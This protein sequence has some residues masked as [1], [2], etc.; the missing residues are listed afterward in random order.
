MKVCLFNNLAALQGA[1]LTSNQK[2]KEGL[3]GETKLGHHSMQDQD[4]IVQGDTICR[5][6]IRVPTA[7]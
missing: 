1:A 2:Q 5:G 7:L 4:Q 6:P 3:Q